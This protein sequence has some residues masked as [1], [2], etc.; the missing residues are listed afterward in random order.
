MDVFRKAVDVI[1]KKLLL[2]LKGKLRLGTSRYARHF[3]IP[4]AFARS[5]KHESYLDDIYLTILSKTK[6]AVID[7]GVNV[8][9]TLLKILSIDKNRLYYGFEPQIIAAAAVEFFHLHCLIK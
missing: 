5:V 8:G 9:Q 4:I 7:V 3:C 2:L 1:T 6:G